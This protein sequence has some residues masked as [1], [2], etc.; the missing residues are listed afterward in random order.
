MSYTKSSTIAQNIGDE[1]GNKVATFANNP[2]TNNVS[3]TTAPTFVSAEI[4]SD[5]PRKVIV[6]FSENIADNTNLTNT[7]YAVRVG[8]VSNRTTTSAV[9]NGK[10]EITISTDISKGQQVEIKYTRKN[11]DARIKDVDGNSV[12]TFTGQTVINNIQ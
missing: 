5:N 3:D 1:T 9:N 6:T 12:L 7:D 2:V 10:L 8:N 11:E 4:T